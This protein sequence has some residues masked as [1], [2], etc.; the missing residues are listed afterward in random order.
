MGKTQEDRV[1]QIFLTTKEPGFFQLLY[2]VLQFEFPNEFTTP[3]T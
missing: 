3:L 1:R 2:R